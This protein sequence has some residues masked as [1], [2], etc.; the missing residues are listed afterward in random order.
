MIAVL[1]TH[2]DVRKIAVQYGAAAAASNSPV[3]GP[4]GPGGRRQVRWVGGVVW[5][6]D[7]AGALAVA[8]RVGL[9]G[10][11]GPKAQRAIFEGPPER[12]RCAHFHAGAPPVA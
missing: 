5:L 2:E 11:S 3:L 7:L 6:D 12:R 8:R 4:A 1:Q 9:L 10:L